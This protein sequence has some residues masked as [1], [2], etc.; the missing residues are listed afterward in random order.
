LFVLFCFVFVL[1]WYGGRLS[2]SFPLAF[3]ISP[4]LFFFL[5]PA[6]P[7]HLFF[8]LILHFLFG[9]FLILYIE[10]VFI[11]ERQECCL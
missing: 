4:S 7:S 5:L 10:L 1:F 2:I 11:L 8:F 6:F 9:H 3:C